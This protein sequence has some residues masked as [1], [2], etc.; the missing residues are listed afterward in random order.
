MTLNFKLVGRARTHS[1]DLVQKSTVFTSRDDRLTGSFFSV[2]NR[3]C[4]GT[5]SAF[6]STSSVTV[7]STQPQNLGKD[8]GCDL[9]W[10]EQTFRPETSCKMQTIYD[11]SPE[12]PK[13]SYKSYIKLWWHG[14]IAMMPILAPRVSSN[15]KI[16]TLMLNV[17]G[18]VPD[19]FV[20]PE[21]PWSVASKIRHGYVCFYVQLDIGRQHLE[22]TKYGTNRGKMAKNKYSEY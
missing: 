18:T 12:Q 8:F 7:A 6:S 1:K 2:S 4:P 5:S 15:K 20:S 16:R 13:Y 10:H 22:R 9:I 17:R 21:M 14:M 11:Q 3:N 19:R